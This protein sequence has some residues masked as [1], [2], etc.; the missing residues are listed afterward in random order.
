[1]KRIVGYK[2]NHLASRNIQSYT[3]KEHIYIFTPNI[4]VFFSQIANFDK[5]CKD[6]IISSMTPTPETC[7]ILSEIVKIENF[8]FDFK[9]TTEA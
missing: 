4:W 1:M 5:N 6:T 8:G 2:G 9:D 3:V 7:Q